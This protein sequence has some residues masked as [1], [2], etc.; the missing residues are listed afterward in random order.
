MSRA[1]RRRVV[2]GSE[3]VT[4]T[5]GSRQGSF[6]SSDNNAVGA[7]ADKD[8][9]PILWLG[10]HDNDKERKTKKKQR[11]HPKQ[12]QQGHTAVLRVY[13]RILS[14]L[15]VLLFF[16][17]VG[18]LSLYVLPAPTPGLLT[19]HPLIFDAVPT[20]TSA[21]GTVC[22]DD[23]EQ[24]VMNAFQSRGWTIIPLKEELAYKDC[25]MQAKAAVIW[26]KNK[27][28]KKKSSTLSGT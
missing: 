3:H 1:P 24:A 15:L 26:T 12:Q 7:T 25:H 20:T 21:A 11:R 28:V 13:E 10:E 19:K 27:Y 2:G 4:T 18:V 6:D 9:S 5:T 14:T 8:D 16:V 17:T 22:I 23:S